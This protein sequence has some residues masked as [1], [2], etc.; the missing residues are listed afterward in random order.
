MHSKAGNTQRGFVNNERGQALVEFSFVL[1]LLCMLTFGIM[2]FGRIF[3]TQM[4]LQNAVRQAGRLAVT[5][6]H[7]P[8]P[9]NA[10][11]NLSRVASITQAAKK[12]A[13]G[14]DLTNIQI[15]STTGGSSGAGRAGG[16]RDTVTISLTTSL[17]LFTPMIGQFFG[18]SGV[19]TF[20]VAT[21]FLNEPF[22]PSQT[23]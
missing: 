5:G 6:N 11:Q 18:T 23:T 8:D 15:T 20:T 1:F 19:Y 12:A 17:R 9:N 21:T 7:L 3:F 14:L 10:G 22:S 4:T 13:P 16:P 2:D